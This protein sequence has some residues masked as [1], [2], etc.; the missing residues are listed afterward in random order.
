MQSAH[1]P[2]LIMT[3]MTVDPVFIDRMQ[4]IQLQM[5]TVYCL[6]TIHLMEFDKRK[7]ETP[8]VMV[9]MFS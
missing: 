9:S 6:A 8:H 4:V 2:D 5:S 3:V 7:Y 1:A